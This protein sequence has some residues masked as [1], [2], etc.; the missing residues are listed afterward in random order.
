MTPVSGSSGPGGTG[1]VTIGV[2]IGTTSVKALAVDPDGAVV[3][4]VRVPHRVIT[5]APDRLEHDARRAWRS[6]PARAY[7]TLE[8]E[9]TAAGRRVGGVCVSSMVPS[10]TA[11]NRRGVPLTAGLL[12]GD[13][14]GRHGRDDGAVGATTGIMRDAEGFLAWAVDQVPGAAG[15]WPAQAVA[16]RAIAGRAVIDTA[17]TASLGALHS[18]G[19]WDPDALAAAGVTED[20]MPAVAPMGQAAGTVAGSDT[21]LCGG[22]V[23]ALCDQLVAGASE[24]GD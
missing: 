7:R 5:E 23:D 13:V 24:V 17:M 9:M 18:F 20:H 8:A 12:Y 3:A 21:V 6:G 2:D 15:Y 11:V 19:R 16:S 1:A 22:T 4:R 10:M 14:R